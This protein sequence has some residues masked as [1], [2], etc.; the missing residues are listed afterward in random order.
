LTC[1]KTPQ[2]GPRWEWMPR[3]VHSAGGGRL[4]CRV[5]VQAGWPIRRLDS[6]ASQKRAMCCAGGSE[7]IGSPRA[8][9]SFVGSRATIPMDRLVGRACAG[10]GQTTEARAATNPRRRGTFRDAEGPLVFSECAGWMSARG[11]QDAADSSRRD[12]PLRPRRQTRAPGGP[13]SAAR[14]FPAGRERRTVHIKGVL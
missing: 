13:V 5:D 2:P 6:T 9:D 7:C 8:G 3:A 14:F 4:P 1:G 10:R 11:T 12:A